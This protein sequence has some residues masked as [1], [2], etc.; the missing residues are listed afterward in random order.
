MV[1]AGEGP[2]R[3]LDPPRFPILSIQTRQSPARKTF[4]NCS[5]LKLAAPSRW[6][7]AAT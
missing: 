7:M 6:F 5:Q 4:N 2:A 1:A 3:A